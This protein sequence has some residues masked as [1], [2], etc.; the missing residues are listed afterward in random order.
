MLNRPMKLLLACSAV[1][2]S[3]ATIAIASS[4]APASAQGPSSPACR[5]N[6][7]K[8]PIVTDISPGSQVQLSCTGLAPLHP[9]LLTELSLVIGI[10]PAASGLLTGSV[11]SLSGL[12]SLLSSLGLLNAGSL[13]FVFSDLNG[14]LSVTYTVPSTQALD[15]NA[16][17]P[18]STTE[19]NSGL[20][21]CALAMIDLTSFKPVGAGSS[22]LEY[23]GFPILP[24]A[25]QSPTLALSTPSAGRGETVNVTDAPGA[26]TYWWLSTLA[27]LDSLLGGSGGTGT[28]T[29]QMGKKLKD[30]TP[31]TST[32]TVTPASYVSGPLDY[33][34]TFT[35]PALTGSFT[36]PTSLNK[37]GYKVVVTET[38][39]ITG[40]PI[41]ISATT[42]LKVT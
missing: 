16:S 25:D 27:T 17:C 35:P 42:K 28:V 14:D 18:P 21:G 4:P 32:A 29:V 6:G 34:G 33:P 40:L 13:D 41:S 1:F 39:T 11:T 26:T 19:Y 9:Y 36:V 3:A 2:V 37:G 7:N 38:A 5:F 15:P 10:D 20:L 8:L 31:V 23:Q 30:L 22:V 12:E 24:S